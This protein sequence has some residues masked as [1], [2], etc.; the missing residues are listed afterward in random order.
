MSVKV[1]SAAV[2]KQQLIRETMKIENPEEYKRIREIATLKH[3]AQ[4]AAE[5]AQDLEAYL[6][7]GRDYA[8][9]FRARQR[10]AAATADIENLSSSIA[11]INIT[12]NIS[13]Q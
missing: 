1:S 8:R 6:K 4:R 5:K 9:M 12:E 2:L 11:T 10:A 13:V 7:R 3:R